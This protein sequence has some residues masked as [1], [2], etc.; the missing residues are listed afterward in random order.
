MAEKSKQEFMQ[1]FLNNARKKALNIKA[2]NRGTSTIKQIE[3]QEIEAKDED[4]L[5]K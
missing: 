5:T 1:R 3:T 4:W 2:P